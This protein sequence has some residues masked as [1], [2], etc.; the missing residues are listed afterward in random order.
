M[1]FNILGLGLCN[2][3]NSMRVAN[4][5]ISESESESEWTTVILV[6]LYWSFLEM[7]KLLLLTMDYSDIKKDVN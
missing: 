4:K 1:V 2:E 7:Y 6:Q 5:H 3:F